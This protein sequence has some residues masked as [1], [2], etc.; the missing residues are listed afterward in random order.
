MRAPTIND[1][2]LPALLDRAGLVSMLLTVP[3]LLH[4]RGVAEATMAVTGLCFLGRSWALRDWS[5]LRTPWVILGTAWL[6]WLIL[7]STP[8]PALGLGE[9]GWNSFGQ[10]VMT[11]RFLLFAAAMEFALLRNGSA[12]RWL[13]G[14]VA[15]AAAY[16]AANCVF[17]F[18]VGRNLYG[19]PRYGEGELTGP[20]G[21]PRAGPPL[22]RI[23]LPSILPPVAAWLARPGLP[24]RFGAYGLLLASVVVMVLIGQ[25]MPLLLT[26]GGLL[27]V[28]VL[29]PQLRKV[30]LVAGV[31]IALLLAASPVIAPKAYNRLVVKFSTQM[32]HF[33]SSH[34]GLLYTRGLEIGLRHPITGLGFDGFGTGCGQPA[35]FRPS[36]DGR[37]PEGGGARICWVHPHN[38]FVQAMTDGGFIGLAL[39]SA[40]SVAWLIALGRGLWQRPN[41]LRIGLFASM[42]VQ[43]WP[44]QSTT[45]FMALPLAGWF[46]LL[47]GWG[48]AL[49]RYPDPVEPDAPDARMP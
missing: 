26:I 39:F 13:F 40:L 28:A 31:A 22:A 49:A 36:F 2:R 17:Q 44:I 42:A 43:I 33:A 45:G 24:A 20:F 12:R 37:E 30:V 27:V 10:A 3:L 23:L 9:G 18:V 25:R 16:I 47:L 48:L 1:P 5:W 35:Y 34:Y 8:I 19:W 11:V 41:A 21:M 14:L 4:A 38:Y 6:V 7:C 32:E 29:L 15:A 46:F